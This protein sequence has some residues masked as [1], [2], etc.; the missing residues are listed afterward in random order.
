MPNNRAIAAIETAPESF[1]VLTRRAFKQDADRGRVDRE[2]EPN[3]AIHGMSVITLGEALGHF[4]WIDDDF[5]DELVTAGN[6]RGRVKSRFTH[7]DASSDGLGKQL[8]RVSTFARDGDQVYADLHFLKAASKAPQGD[9]AGYTMDLAEEVPEDFGTSIVFWRDFGA[10]ERFA[11]EHTDEEGNFQSPDGR[12]EKNLPHWRLRKLDAVDVVD[13]PAANAGGLFSRTSEFA[14]QADQVA[15]FALGLTDEEPAVAL[16]DRIHPARVKRFAQGF[17]ARRGLKVVPSGPGVPGA[18]S[19]HTEGDAGMEGQKTLT[20]QQDQPAPPA[21]VEQPG[22]DAAAEGDVVVDVA[23]ELA[24][25]R[26]EAV[27]AERARFAALKEA[28]PDRDAFVIEQF[29]AGASLD[30]AKDAFRDV[31]LAELAAE[32]ADLKKRVGAK[33]VGFAGEPEEEKSHLQ[34]A[35]EYQAEHECSMTEAL[36]ATAPKRQK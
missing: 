13:E 11:A 36:R 27:L 22:T 7:P 4:A 25:A 21:T 6:E 23:A 28:F 1:R 16:F 26:A 2:A 3:G 19:I 10:E 20:Q 12:N 32:N 35:R 29:E 34:R 17:L 31:R 15:A 30:E 24:A 33:P 14:A 8:G 9:L 5:L 18:G